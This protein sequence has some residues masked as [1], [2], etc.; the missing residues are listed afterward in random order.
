MDDYKYK[1]YS[2]GNMSNGLKGAM[3]LYWFIRES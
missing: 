3:D 2:D 1:K